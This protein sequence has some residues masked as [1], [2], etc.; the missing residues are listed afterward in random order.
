MRRFGLHEEQWERIKDPLPGREGS[1][2]VTAAD[3]RLS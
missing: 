1:F 2:G 3:N